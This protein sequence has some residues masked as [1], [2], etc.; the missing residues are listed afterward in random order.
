VRRFVYRDD[1]RR[2]L[3]LRDELADQA[4]PTTISAGSGC[5]PAS[6]FSLVRKRDVVAA[7]VDCLKAE[8]HRR[9]SLDVSPA[10]PHVETTMCRMFRADLDRLERAQDPVAQ[11]I[12]VRHAGVGDVVRAGLDLLERRLT[13]DVVVAVDDDQESS[14][15]VVISAGGQS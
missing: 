12:G 15:A 5:N 14:E 1:H 13:D 7:A 4:G 6:G 9:H 2:I 11:E 8:L 10:D 3:R